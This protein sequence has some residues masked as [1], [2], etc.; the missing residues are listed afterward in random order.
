M[1]LVINIDSIHH[2]N[3]EH[4]KLNISYNKDQREREKYRRHVFREY[5]I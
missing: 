3:N 1:Y 4:K 2:L 5:Q